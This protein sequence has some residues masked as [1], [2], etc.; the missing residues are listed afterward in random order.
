MKTCIHAMMSFFVILATVISAG[1]Q[2]LPDDA[3][4]AAWKAF[5]QARGKQWTVHWHPNRNARAPVRFGYAAVHR[6]AGSC[7]PNVSGVQCP[8]VQDARESFHPRGCKNSAAP[9][10]D[11]RTVPANHEQSPHSGGGISG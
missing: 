5:N 10:Q 4:L 11:P 7:G 6:T 1:A 8:D 9:R 3:Q 2:K